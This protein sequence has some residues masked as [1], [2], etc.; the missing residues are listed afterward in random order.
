MFTKPF[1][2]VLYPSVSLPCTDLRQS[3]LYIV[4]RAA[5]GILRKKGAAKKGALALQRAEASMLEQ[6]EAVADTVCEICRKLLAETVSF[7]ETD[8]EWASRRE[9]EPVDSPDVEDILETL[10]SHLSDFIRQSGR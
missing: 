7:V 4:V 2:F 10:C 1:L 8:R 5:S 9:D 3:S 6:A